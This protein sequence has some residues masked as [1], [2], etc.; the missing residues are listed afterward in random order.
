MFTYKRRGI[1]QKSGKEFAP[2]P[3]L[4]LG[5]TSFTRIRKTVGLGHVF[6]HDYRTSFSTRLGGYDVG[7]DT[8]SIF[9]GHT[10]AGVTADYAFRTTIVESLVSADDKLV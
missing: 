1:N 7:K 9:M 2:R 4:R 8:I 3:I 5:G 10:I 6:F